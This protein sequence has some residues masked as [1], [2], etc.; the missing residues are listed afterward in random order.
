MILFAPPAAEVVN[1]QAVD[2]VHNRMPTTVLDIRDVIL[3]NHCPCPRDI[4]CKVNTITV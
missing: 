2:T 1:L 3:M 4:L